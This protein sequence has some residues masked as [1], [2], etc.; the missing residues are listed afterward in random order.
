MRVSMTPSRLRRVGAAALAFSMAATA[1]SAQQIFA[2]PEEAARALVKATE[3][4]RPGD[5]DQLFGPGA[6]DLISTGDAAE[7]QRRIAAFRTAAAESVDLQ[8]AGD[9]T[10]VMALGR[11]A[12][13]FPIPIVKQASG[14]AFDLKAGREELVNRAVGFNEL[15]AVEACRAYVAAQKEYF[16]LD[17]DED[18][19]AEYAQRIVSTPG[20]RDGLYWES[21]AQG[22]VSPL[23]DRLFQASTA[24]KAGREPY[25][26]YYFRV[27]KAQGPAAP[28][29][30]HSY[31]INGHMIAG[32][33]LV[34]YP[35][36]WGR[37][38]VMTF[39]CNQQGKIFEQ[40]LGLET[41]ARASAM[42]AYDPGKGWRLVQ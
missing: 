1:V 37:T 29:G 14:W 28:G 35:A 38:G 21:T 30:A 34:A 23:D 27:L 41:A 8:P 10:R 13:P 20:K 40:D 32:F 7:D 25:R 4:P 2:S 26:G 15:S 18:E 17:R 16:R 24:V 31:V 9:A 36:D 5:L 22:D 12:W 42:S 11:R 19:V 3:Q 6:R 33:G 39:I